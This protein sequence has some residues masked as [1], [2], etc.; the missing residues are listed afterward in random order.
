[1]GAITFSTGDRQTGALLMEAGRGEGQRGRG[2]RRE[3]E[4]EENDIRRSG[5]TW[6][7]GTEAEVPAM[8]HGHSLIRATLRRAKWNRRGRDIGPALSVPAP[9]FPLYY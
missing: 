7:R 9:S 4:G 5:T 1:M 3:R 8:E 6:N 2:G